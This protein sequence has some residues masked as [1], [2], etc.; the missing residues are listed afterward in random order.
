MIDEWG[1]L[2]ISVERMGKNGEPEYHSLII[3][4]GTF[5]KIECNPYEVEV[6]RM[7]TDTE[8]NAAPNGGPATRPGDSGVTQ[9]PPWVS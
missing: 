4:E 7:D 3:D 1:R 8:P 2:W 5:D 9:G 6:E